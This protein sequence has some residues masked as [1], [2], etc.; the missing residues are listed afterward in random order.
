MA[1][2]F[3]GKHYATFLSDVRSQQAGRNKLDE[4][5]LLASRRG[6][7]YDGLADLEWPGYSSQGKHYA[8][9]LSDVRSQQAGRN[10]L[11]EPMFLAN[12]RG[13]PYDGL[14]DGPARGQTRQAGLT[15]QTSGTSGTGRTG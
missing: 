14:A 11:D 7:P 3:Q 1:R 9:F 4:P 12:R 6:C 5:M 15:N 2:L 10:K 8:T 13:C